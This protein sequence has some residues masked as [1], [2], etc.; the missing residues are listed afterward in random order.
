MITY[1]AKHFTYTISH[2]REGKSYCI[3]HPGALWLQR[4]AS[5]NSHPEATAKPRGPALT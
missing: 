4:G 2:K 3:I 5:P 1:C